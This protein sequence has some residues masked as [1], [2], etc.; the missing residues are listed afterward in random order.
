MCHC[1]RKQQSRYLGLPKSPSSHGA[2]PCIL[3]NSI[4][5]KNPLTPNT[6]SHPANLSVGRP[7]DGQGRDELLI[8]LNCYSFGKHF[9]VFFPFDGKRTEK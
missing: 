4:F 5:P 6:V 9:S 8:R 7:L 3:R 2:S 1:L